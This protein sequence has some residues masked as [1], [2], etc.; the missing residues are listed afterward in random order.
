MIES[1]APPAPAQEIS[2]QSLARATRFALAMIVMALA[3]FPFRF[4]LG[5]SKFERIF[6]DMLGAGSQLPIVTTF[7]LNAA[8]A[9]IAISAAILVV[10]IA[11]LFMRNIPRALYILG[12][13]AIV[14]VV[15][16]AVVF[17]ALI[18]PLMEII[19]RMQGTGP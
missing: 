4:S 12:A 16:C 1:S 18:S 9:V 19:K 6:E 8:P 3:Y 15:N 5:I 7:V 17:V 14:A 2:L 11:V 13:L 10:P